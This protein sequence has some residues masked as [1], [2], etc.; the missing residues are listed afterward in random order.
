VEKAIMLFTMGTDSFDLGAGVMK[1]YRQH[2]EFFFDK[3]VMLITLGTGVLWFLFRSNI[4]DSL[5]DGFFYSSSSIALT[6][7]L[8]IFIAQLP[9]QIFQD[10]SVAYCR[11]LRSTFS[12][13]WIR[14]VCHDC[15]AIFGTLGV[16]FNFYGRALSPQC[17]HGV[18]LWNSQRC[19][20][21]AKVPSIPTDSV[22]FLLLLPLYLQM[23]FSG[24]SFN[25]SF[26]C[27]CLTTAFIGLAITQ[28]GGHLDVW[29]FLTS[30]VVLLTMYNYERLSRI[31][32]LRY[33]HVNRV[34]FEKRGLIGLQ[35]QAVNDLNFEKVSHMTEIFKMRSQEEYR[36]IESEKRY[37]IALL[38]NVA[39]D[40]KTPL[41]SFLMDLEALKG[42]IIQL[43]RE[44]SHCALY[45]ISYRMIGGI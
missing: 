24:L 3:N 31:T 21:V 6:L 38:G 34:E 5:N 41:Q 32:F 37:T 17:P 23:L 20:H 25:A 26:A 1:E 35:M 15:L 43:Q 29:I 45:R 27:F 39:H 40:L 11:Y 4:L 28:V 9:L 30:F 36:L 16:C 10:S 19:N 33:C 22:V 7:T 18:S 44:F 14:F 2:K 42:A 8:A 13:A 12:V